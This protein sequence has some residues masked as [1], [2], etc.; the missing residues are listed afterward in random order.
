MTDFDAR[1]QVAI[2]VF[3]VVYMCYFF[4]SALLLL[5]HSIRLVDST[6]ARGYAWKRGSGGGGGAR[7]SQENRGEFIVFLA[8]S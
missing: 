1:S 8:L 2:G 5:D 6:S 4:F 7:Q 3:L